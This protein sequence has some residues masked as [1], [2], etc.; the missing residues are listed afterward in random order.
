MTNKSEIKKR[1]L[2]YFLISF[3]IPF[4]MAG[5]YIAC[6]GLTT[7][8]GW[9]AVLT[10]LAMLCPTVANI[11]TRI[12][13]KEGFENSLF[14][15]K[16]KGNLHYFV[17]ALLFPVIYSTINAFSTAIFLMP[18]GSLAEMMKQFDVMEFITMT[19]YAESVGMITVIFGFGEEFGWRGYLTPKLERLF[20]QPI[21]IIVSGIIWGL[22]HAP[23]IICGHNFGKDYSGYPY[24]GIV[25][26]CLFCIPMG[27]LFTVLTQK[28]NSVIPASFCHMAV[29]SVAGVVFTLFVAN[30][31]N[32]NENILGSIRYFMIEL[33]CV[34]VTALVFGF[35]LL[36]KSNN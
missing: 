1:I 8:N 25:V 24:V 2:I 9:Y 36:K 13:T 20:S 17:I 6:F 16:I 12:I 10:P 18:K 35:I 14:K 26:M 5:I 32:F 3:G 30:I 29:D 22:W 21:A 19:L 28:T 4:I 23:L 33:I 11:L 27:F 31:E 34:S 15:M 7:E